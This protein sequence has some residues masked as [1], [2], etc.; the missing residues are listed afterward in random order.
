MKQN[1]NMIEI[2]YKISLTAKTLRV[3]KKSFKNYQQKLLKQLTDKG[4]SVPK[5]YL[6]LNHRQEYKCNKAIYYANKKRYDF[7]LRVLML[8]YG[9]TQTYGNKYTSLEL[10]VMAFQERIKEEDYLLSLD[11]ICR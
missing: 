5:A 6:E 7:K 8:A 4:Y 10:I 11:F 9:L 2:G 3:I 1:K